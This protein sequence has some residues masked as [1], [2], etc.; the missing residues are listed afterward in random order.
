M[1]S[2]RHTASSSSNLQFKDG[3]LVIP[4]YRFNKVSNQQCGWIVRRSCAPFRKAARWRDTGS[5]T[6]V[7]EGW[8]LKDGAHVLAKIALAHSSASMCLERELHV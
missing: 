3:L 6:D 7:A 8:K 5:E 1:T 4:G 2:H